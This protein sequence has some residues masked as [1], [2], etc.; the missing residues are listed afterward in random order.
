MELLQQIRGILPPG[1]TT[2]LVVDLPRI[3]QVFEVRDKEGQFIGHHQPDSIMP[4]E[5]HINY[6]WYRWRQIELREKNNKEHTPPP[7]S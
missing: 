5:V 2:R 4:L 7:Q 6:W 1:W 3:P